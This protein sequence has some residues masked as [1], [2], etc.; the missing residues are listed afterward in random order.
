MALTDQET[1]RQLLANGFS[2][3]QTT[4]AATESK[5]DQLIA[6]I[7]TLLSE[8]ATDIN[9]E[10]IK[11]LLTNFLAEN[12]TEAK[13]NEAIAVLDKLNQQLELSNSVGTVQPSQTA[14]ANSTAQEIFA[15]SGTRKRVRITNH[16]ASDFIL[17]EVNGDASLVQGQIIGAGGTWKS[18]G[19]EEARS[20]ITVI[21]GT[22][23]NIPISYQETSDSVFFVSEPT[24]TGLANIL[25]I[26]Y[27]VSIAGATQPLSSLT[28]NLYAE[29][30]AA[31]IQTTIINAG[32]IPGAIVSVVFSGVNGLNSSSQPREFYLE[33]IGVD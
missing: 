23:A 16:S 29:G 19:R 20:R 8:N 14:I 4:Q 17:I 33:L 32:L 1:L 11:L 13:Q 25:E 22:G 7:N 10:E 3:G 15:L 5:Q 12:A 6:S 31:I 9:Q 21:S 30:E 2:G 26:T 28:A 27:P 24:I 18:P